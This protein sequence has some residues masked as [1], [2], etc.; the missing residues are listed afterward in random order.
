MYQTQPKS[1]EDRV[2][3]KEMWSKRNKIGGPGT[4]RSFRGVRK[5]ETWNKRM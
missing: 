1:G 5:T 2:H 4:V 3:D